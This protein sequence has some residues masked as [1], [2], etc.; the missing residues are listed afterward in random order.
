MQAAQGISRE[1]DRRLSQFSFPATSLISQPAKSGED[2]ELDLSRMSRYGLH[3]SLAER[4]VMG[5]HS[6][7]LVVR[8][9]GFVGPSQL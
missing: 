4:L 8:A 1:L 9:G 6:D 2:R 5:A 3:K 7:W